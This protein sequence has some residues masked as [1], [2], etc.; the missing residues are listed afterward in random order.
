MSTPVVLNHKQQFIEALANYEASEHARQVLAGI[1][2]AILLSV[3]AG[4]RNTVIDELNKTGRYHTVVSDTTRPP[5][6]RNG[7]MERDG[8]NYHFRSEEEV[9]D[10]IRSGEYLEA[11][12]IHNQQV[13]GIS[14]RELERASGNGKIAINEVELLGTVNIRRA[15][16]D[17]FMIFLMPPSFDEWMRRVKNRETM[18]D[19]EFRNRMET[20]E[21][22]LKHVLEVDYFHF[23]VNDTVSEAARQIDEIVTTKMLP[24][25][26]ESL[27]QIVQEMLASTRKYLVES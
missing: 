24:R 16:P 2:L 4:G 18:S 3:F 10:D 6:F 7:A 11:E 9:L 27:C 15:K 21:R 22:I 17:A 13:S 12:V 20:A 5:K 25:R 19:Q 23:V 8:I 26:D 14:I 1:D